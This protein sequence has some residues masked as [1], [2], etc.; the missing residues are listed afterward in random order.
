MGKPD[1]W[2]TRKRLERVENGELE[3]A[4]RLLTSYT[5]GK[6]LCYSNLGSDLVTAVANAC[7]TA[8]KSTKIMG[9][10]ILKNLV[11]ALDGASISGSQKRS[12]A[13]YA[14][15]TLGEE[16]GVKKRVLRDYAMTFNQVQRLNG[17]GEYLI[18]GLEYRSKSNG[19]TVTIDLLLVA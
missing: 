6:D 2:S 9:N 5:D 8:H 16:F 17:D 19:K 10:L 3:E 15:R 12:E 4:D 14:L 13:M 7:S 11:S 18:P 1:Y